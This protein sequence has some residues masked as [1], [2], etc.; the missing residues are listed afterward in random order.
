MGIEKKQI[1]TWQCHET[2]IRCMTLISSVDFQLLVTAS[3]SDHMIKLWDVSDVSQITCVGSV[4][5]TCR[6]TSLSTW[7]RGMMKN[8]RKKKNPVVESVS[9]KTASPKKK[10][11]KAETRDEGTKSTD[12][13]SVE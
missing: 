12:V 13:L 6:V 7:H 11:K 10:L 3:S 9:E 5:T 8:K 4:D 1:S 2:R